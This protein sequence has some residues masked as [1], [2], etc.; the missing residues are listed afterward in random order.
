MLL[1]LT[2]V[3]GNAFYQSDLSS[4]EDLFQFER[5]HVLS[6]NAENSFT[7]Y[8]NINDPATKHFEKTLIYPR[9]DFFVPADLIAY[10]LP[11][12]IDIPHL[13]TVENYL[14]NL[15]YAN[16]MIKKLL[17]EQKALQERARNALEGLSVPFID[18]KLSTFD[19]KSRDRSIHNIWIDLNRDQLIAAQHAG[20]ADLS[21]IE[22]LTDLRMRLRGAGAE[23]TALYLATGSLSK[24]SGRSELYLS[25]D[26]MRTSRYRRANGANASIPSSGTAPEAP[27]HVSGQAKM[28]GAYDKSP[29]MPWVIRLPSIM[30][31]YVVAHPFE[32]LFYLIL[33]YGLIAAF[34]SKRSS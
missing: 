27:P 23:G 33:L 18:S 28:T 4:K 31:K 29:D 26:H 15:V 19:L 25:D 30:A 22:T 11:I 34:R 21:G 17:K 5:K 13:V 9:S 20:S 16:L 32:G 1:A 2:P 3:K 6:H 14:A 24:R 7:V 12:N 8:D 10:N